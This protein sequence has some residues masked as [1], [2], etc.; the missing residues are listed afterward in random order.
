MSLMNEDTKLSSVLGLLVYDVPKHMSRKIRPHLKLPRL[1][2][3]INKSCWLM[4]AANLTRIPFDEWKQAG[5]DIEFASDHAGMVK[6]AQK[7][8]LREV[9]DISVRMWKAV[10]K[11]AKAYDEAHE[12]IANDQLLRDADHLTYVAMRRTRVALAEA[13]EAALAFDVTH[14]FE[15][16]FEAIRQAMRAH[17][18]TLQDQRQQVKAE[19]TMLALR[20]QGV[21]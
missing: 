1:A 8:L 16:L 21:A 5:V 13:Q 19:K 15:D 6:L 9:K 11:A 2:A 3:R 20:K 12:H 4:P 17:S 10:R 7:G 18:E 14:D